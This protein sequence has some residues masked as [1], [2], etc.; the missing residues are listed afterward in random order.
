M[1]ITRNRGLL[2]IRWNRGLLIIRDPLI[3]HPR[4]SVITTPAVNLPC[5]LFAK[6]PPSGPPTPTEVVV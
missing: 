4:I 2:I 6:A 1:I 3:V 5:D